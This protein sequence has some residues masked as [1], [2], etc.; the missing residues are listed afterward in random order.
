MLD[1][2]LARCIESDFEP[3]CGVYFLLNDGGVVHIGQSTNVAQRVNGHR[4]RAKRRES[5]PSHKPLIEFDRVLFL[6]VTWGK[7]YE[8]EGALIRAFKPAHNR[9]VPSATWREAEILKE[10]GLPYHCELAA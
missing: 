8:Y 5:E 1:A 7:R 9:N 3:Q 6:P 10:L 4:L 2:V